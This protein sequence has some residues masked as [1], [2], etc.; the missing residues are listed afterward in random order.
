MWEMMN[1]YE[2]S[3]RVPLLVRP[4][5]HDR[6]FADIVSVYDHPVELLDLLP[7]MATLAGLPPPPAEWQ[8]P[9][10]DLSRGM[11]ANEVVKPINAAFGQITRCVNCTMAYSFSSGLAACTKDHVADAALYLTPCA[12]TQRDMFDWMGMSVR[13]SHWRYSVFC[14]WDG[15]AL[16]ANFSSC[17]PPELYNHSSDRSLFDVDSNGEQENLAGNAEVEEQERELRAKLME[18]FHA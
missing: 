10:S 1:L 8:L 12:E 17:A 18:R 11:I 4:A 7:T 3:L 5:P 13:T 14:R 6:R 16:Q 9:G 2:Q 15:V